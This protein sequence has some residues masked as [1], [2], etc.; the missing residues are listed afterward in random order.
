MI[1]TNFPI[2]DLRRRKFQTSISIIT[3][4]LSVASTLFLLILTNRIGFGTSSAAEIL[5]SGLT[6]IFSQFIIFI[7]VLIFIIGAVLT[8]YASFL[9]TMQ[10]TRDFG[11]IKAAGCPNNLIGGYLMAELLITT[12]VGCT[13]GVGLGFIADFGVSKLMFLSY[14]LPNFL[15]APLV[16]VAFFIVALVFGL[17]PVI[18]ASRMSALQALSPVNYYGLTATGKH[19]ALSK[20]ALTWR[21]ASRSLT[22]RQSASI[23]III[24]LSIVFILL[25][26]SVGGGIIASGT[27]TTWVQQSSD[28]YVILV[29]HSSIAE[30]YK[31]L[32]AMFTGGKATVDFDYSNIKLAIPQAAIQQIKSL[33]NVKVVDSRLMLKEHVKEISNFTINSETG[34]TFPVG[35]DRQAD[36]LVIGV[37]PSSVV[38]SWFV[39]GRFFSKADAP[40]AVIGD[41]VGNTMYA[42]THGQ[43]TMMSNPLLEGMELRNN[44]FNIV[45]VCIDPL[46]NGQIVY[47]PLQKITNITGNVNPNLLLIKLDTSAD[48]TASIQQIKATIQSIDPDLNAYELNDIVA[49][50]TAF[51]DTTWQTIML[52]PLFTMASAALCLVGYMMLTV[53]EQ[54]QE[55]AVLRAVGAKSNKVISIL[56]IQSMIVLLSSFAIGISLGTMI[57]LVILLH[58]PIVTT[59]TLIQI[60]GWLLAALTG[61]FILSLYPALKL[62][63]TSI[64]KIIT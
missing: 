23:R 16:F 49:K 19:K 48:R 38:S 46:S 6:A 1:K 34:E 18:K 20:S 7:G 26:V 5:T 30:Q 56:S 3:L 4:T 9:M 63:K 42:A 39:Q 28:Q 60:S 8:A 61:M 25:T 10:R 33:P 12:A 37:D 13:L 31:Q 52:L 55:F 54:R 47:M 35:G 14:Q 43:N 15:F 24:L 11:L 29:A 59:F 27:T 45:G 57:T 41:S 62:A 22:R 58:Q 64:L 17:Q 50:N 2:N 21:L 36:L 51:L 40:E 44:T 53:D 32:L